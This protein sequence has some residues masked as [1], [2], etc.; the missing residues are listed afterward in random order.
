MTLEEKAEEYANKYFGMYYPQEQER[1]AVEQA[2]LA[3]AEEN[4]SK[5]SA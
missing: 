2:Y 1:R 4:L 3:G 5:K